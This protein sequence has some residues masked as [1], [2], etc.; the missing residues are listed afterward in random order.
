MTGARCGTWLP[1][2]Q[3][4]ALGDG[5]SVALV[6]SDGSINWWCVPNLDSPPSSDRLLAG[7]DRGHFSIVPVAP[8]TV[9]RRCRQGSDMLEQ[10]ISTASGQ[11]QVTYLLSSGP[12]GPLPARSSKA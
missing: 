10:V 11:A 1:P 5:R 7:D 9:E 2:G 6:G 4:A 3:Y 12:P 8:F